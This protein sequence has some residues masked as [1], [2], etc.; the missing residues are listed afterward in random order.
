MCTIKA[1][2][3]DIT[4]GDY[5]I[6]EEFVTIINQPRKD[7]EGN[8]VKRTMKIGNY[9]LIECGTQINSSD[10]GDLNEFGVKCA[11]PPGSQIGNCCTISPM[12]TL[13]SNTRLPNYSVYYKEGVIRKDLQPREESRRQNIKE[14]SFAL[15]S[16]LPKQNAIRN[17]GPDGQEIP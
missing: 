16:I 13:P 9:N 7:K 3:G 6:I 11:V 14:M 1:D 15:A 8:F 12:L 4:I 17:I 2:G 10:I 5:T